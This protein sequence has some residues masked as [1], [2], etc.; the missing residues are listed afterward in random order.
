MRLFLLA[1]ICLSAAGIATPAL[2]RDHAVNVPAGRGAEAAVVLAQQT[3][4]SIVLADS[5]LAKRQIPAIR[6]TLSTDQAVKRLAGLLNARAVPAGSSGWR[7]VALKARRKPLFSRPDR[8]QAPAPVTKAAPLPPQPE[9][10]VMG[11]KSDRLLKDYPGQVAII[12]GE[13]LSFGGVGGTEKIMQ[14]VAS[15]SSTHLGSGRNKLFIRGIADSSFTGPTQATVGQYFGDLR[16]SY[17]APDPDLR[18]SDI[19]RVEVLEGPQGTLYG[20][21]SLG[22]IIRIVP[23]APQM[24]EVSGSAMVGG[25]LTQHGSGSG[26]ASLTANLPL[27]EDNLALRI[28]ADAASSGGYIDKPLLGRKNVNRTDI[29]G[30]RAALRFD[31]G[32]GWTVDWIALGQTTRGR[33]SQYAD[34]GGPPLSRSSAVK[35]GF[36]ADYGQGQL[37]ISGQFGEWHVRSSTGITRQKLEERYDATEP[38][39][40]PRLF[41]QQNHTDM[42]ANET[43][44]WKPLGDVFGA[45]LGVSYTH[46]VTKLTRVLGTPG[47]EQA[48]TGVENRINEAT[49][50]GEAS[51]RL[52]PGVVAS[53]GGRITRSSLSGEGEDIDPL[54]AMALVKAGVTAARHSHAF[55]PSASL[56]A[57]VLDQTTLY[58]RYQEGFRPGG[59]AVSGA[60]VSRFKSDHVSTLELGARHGTP[61]ISPVELGMSISYSDWKDIQADY[62]DSAG[63]PGTANIGDGTIWSAT[64][65]A[66][67]ILSSAWR[68]DAGFSYN[69]SRVDEPTGQLFEARLSQVPNIANFSGRVGVD[70]TRRLAN[71]MEL[72]ARGWA[73]Y[74]GDSRLGVGPELGAKQGNYLDSGVT[75]RLSKGAYGLSL[76]LTNLLDEEGNRFALGTPFAIGREQITPLRP[77]SIRIGFEA[78]F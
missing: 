41:T 8:T 24:G 68:V 64:L 76:S 4:T 17:N 27:N 13:A 77:R 33:D 48:T 31:A 39:G 35:E 49:L 45:V 14:R 10:V 63:L 53:G 50:Y 19:E 18:L 44:V 54:L 26:D 25:S 62:L 7:L 60:F 6:G 67:F 47:D 1:P 78:A 2:A 23:N 42:I 52:A 12:S 36:D 28:T 22:G 34:R 55:L 9:I 3:G 21:G 11:S 73:S 75:V 20:A 58:L 46:N 56:S 70:Y 69:D 51:F 61:G 66:A 32:D 16:L 71:G 74:I 29:L 40:D 37:V 38:G 5:A 72:A 43:R 15:V 65:D 57:N 59:L 30:G